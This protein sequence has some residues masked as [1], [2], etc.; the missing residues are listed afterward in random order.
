MSFWEAVQ[1]Y[2]RWDIGSKEVTCLRTVFRVCTVA[3]CVYDLS[4]ASRCMYISLFG[5][6]I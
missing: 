5:G 4:Q 1:G 2:L 6:I 3:S